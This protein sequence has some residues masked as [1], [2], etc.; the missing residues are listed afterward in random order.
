MTNEELRQ[1]RER[2]EKATAGSWQLAYTTD[3]TFV[4]DDSD[5]IVGSFE[6]Q[7][8]AEFIAHAREDIPKFLAEI[9]R[10]RCEIDTYVFHMRC[11]GFPSHLTWASVLERIVFEGKTW[12]LNFQSDK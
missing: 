8:D 9:D 4:L 2:T 12:I 1:I 5:I 7:E 11:S 6:R 3:D 10:L